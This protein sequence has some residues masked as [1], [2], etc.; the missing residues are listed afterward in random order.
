MVPEVVKTFISRWSSAPVTATDLAKQFARA[1][2]ADVEEILQR[3]VTLG[4]AHQ[5]D[6]HFTR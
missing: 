2:P 5:K 4:R 1:N 3:L 6:T